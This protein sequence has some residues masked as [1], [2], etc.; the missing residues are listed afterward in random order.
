MLRTRTLSALR[1]PQRFGSPLP[2]SDCI[3]T[4][5]WNNQRSQLLSF[6]TSEI[7]YERNWFRAGLRWKVEGGRSSFNWRSDLEGLLIADGRLAENSSERE[8]V[9]VIFVGMRMFCDLSMKKQVYV[10][11]QFNIAN[12]PCSL[13]I[14]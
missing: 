2:I 6:A 13:C 5:A 4:R 3:L 10:A 8:L 11:S 9:Q 1:K 12:D 7:L 14:S